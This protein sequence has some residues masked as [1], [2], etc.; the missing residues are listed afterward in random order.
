MND[1]W[2]L[3]ESECSECTGCPL[4]QT[5][6]H[7]V[8]GVGDRNAKVFFVGE[9]PGEKEDQQGEPFVGPAGQ[10]LDKYLAAVGLSRDRVYIGNIV[11]CRPP[12]NRD[13]LPEERE[14]CMEF[15]RRQT[16]LL[17][18][19]IIVCLGRIAAGQLISPEF[20]VTRQHGAWI[21][22][23]QFWIM[24]TFHPAALLR[25]AAQ[26]PAAFEDFLSL[27]GKMKELGIWNGDDL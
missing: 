4:A 6:T 22:K 5:R 1:S 15:L 12:H 21:R 25:N 20:K 9:G 27:R 8:F 13:P 26:K 3:L 7:V 24:G 2:E 14:A 19:E 17:R 23:G 10:L 18:P 11:K 16:R